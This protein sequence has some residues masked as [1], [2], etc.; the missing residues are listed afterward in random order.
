MDD[1]RNIETEIPGAGTIDPARELPERAGFAERARD[2]AHRLSGKAKDAARRQTSRAYDN[3][4]RRLHD[5]EQSLD[6]LA[7][8]PDGSPVARRAADALHR[9]TQKLDSTSPDEIIEGARRQVARRP[10]LAFAGFFALGFLAAR[11]LK[12]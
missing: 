1:R 9:V 5:M 3:L 10:A 11:L 8:R 6:E 7:S 4:G 2:E 12:E